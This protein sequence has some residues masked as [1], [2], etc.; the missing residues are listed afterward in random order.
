MPG[1]LITDDD[2]TEI[3]SPVP[4]W[5]REV[6]PNPRQ[7]RVSAKHRSQHSIQFPGGSLFI[8]LPADAEE[9]RWLLPAIESLSGLGSLPDNWDSYGARS[10]SVHS[11]AGVLRLLSMLMTDTTSLPAFVPVR[12]GGIQ[13]EWHTKG[14]DLEI[15]V[16]PTGLYRASFE[17][18]GRGLE[19]AGDVTSNLG[20][21]REVLTRLAAA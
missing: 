15:E 14:I 1:S 13:L 5:R 2:Y 3:E 19:W 18:S 16:S 4:R 9:P 21:L 6:L 17:D 12:H 11:M 7:S 8:D 20:P 10:I